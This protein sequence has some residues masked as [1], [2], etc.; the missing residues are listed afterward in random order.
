VHVVGHVERES[1]LAK[2]DAFSPELWFVN[3]KIWIGLA[4]G[5]EAQILVD[6]MGFNVGKEYR[7]KPVRLQRQSQ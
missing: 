1:L 3:I 6:M 4:I 5:L 2:L 7:Q